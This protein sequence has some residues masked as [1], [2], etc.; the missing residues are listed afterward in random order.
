MQVQSLHQALIG[1]TEHVEAVNSGQSSF[2]WQAMI[3][4]AVQVLQAISL[5]VPNPII[6]SVLSAAIVVLQ[7]FAQPTPSPTPTTV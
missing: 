5:T 1:A 4:V 3:P 6:K 2:D 7:S